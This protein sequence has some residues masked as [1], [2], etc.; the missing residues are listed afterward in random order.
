MKI[1]FFVPKDVEDFAT[2]LSETMKAKRWSQN[3]QKGVTAEQVATLTMNTPLLEA[4]RNTAIYR[5]GLAQPRP[6]TNL[7][8]QAIE[9]LKERRAAQY[10]AAIPSIEK[11]TV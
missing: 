6:S 2:K 10:P 5:G 3:E 8:E 4:Y 9:L 1:S 11:V 7:Y